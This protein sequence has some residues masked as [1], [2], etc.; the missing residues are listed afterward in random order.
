M[1]EAIECSDDR[2]DSS[3]RPHQVHERGDQKY[4]HVLENVT[5]HFGNATNNPASVR[6]AERY[7]VLGLD[8]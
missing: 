5:A 6:E 2:Y 4:L 8:I 3:S 7:A 1:I